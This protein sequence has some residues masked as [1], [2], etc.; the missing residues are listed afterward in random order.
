MELSRTVV[1][2]GEVAVK[3]LLLLGTEDDGGVDGSERGRQQGSLQQ[4]TDKHTVTANCPTNGILVLAC[5]NQREA[6]V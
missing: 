1:V 3:L 4:S 5:D 6:S 2:G